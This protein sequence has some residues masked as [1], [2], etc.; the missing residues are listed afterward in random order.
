MPAPL[1][2]VPA[3]SPVSEVEVREALHR[4][5]E[6]E[7]DREGPFDDGAHL[8]E[9]LALDSLELTVVAVGLE[10]RFRVRLSEEDAGGIRTM[11]ELVSLVVRRAAEGEGR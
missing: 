7:L 1:P 2:T 10:N 9:G 6:E 5:L 8:M 11:G 4:I 3:S